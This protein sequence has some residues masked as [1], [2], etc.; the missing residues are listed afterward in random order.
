MVKAAGKGKKP[1]R[2]QPQRK[3]PQR[4]QPQRKQP[5]RGRWEGDNDMPSPAYAGSSSVL[6]VHLIRLGRPPRTAV[7]SSII[8]C[9]RLLQRF[10]F[11]SSVSCPHTS[12]IPRPLPPEKSLGMRLL[13]IRGSSVCLCKVH[14]VNPCNG[15]YGIQIWC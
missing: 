5:P 2:K 6:V 9:F 12:L 14:Y 3:Q 1:Q 7:L 11:Y 15:Y 10:F 4:K 13:P 8:I